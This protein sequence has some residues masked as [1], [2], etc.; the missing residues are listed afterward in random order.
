MSTH[1]AIDEQLCALLDGELA[2]EQM[3]F[4]LKRMARDPDLAARWER[5]QLASAAL[6]RI[7]LRALPAGFAARVTAA[8]RADGA[9]RGTH[10]RWGAGVA[11]AASVAVAAMLVSRPAGDPAVDGPLADRMIASGADTAPLLPAITPVTPLTMSP[12]PTLTALSLVGEDSLIVTRPWP[13]AQLDPRD[14]LHVVWRDR[15]SAAPPPPRV[16]DP[17]PRR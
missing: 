16:A 13:R 4:L 2:P 12:V 7:D 1:T 14:P 6:R 15:A 8:L 3:R 10:W 9:S 17:S 11:L 5:W